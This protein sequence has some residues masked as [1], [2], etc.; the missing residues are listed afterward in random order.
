VFRNGDQYL[1]SDAVFGVRE[2]LIADWVEQPGG[3][4]LLNFD[5][6]LNESNA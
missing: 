2:S 5:F 4:T 3:D 6:V 1:E